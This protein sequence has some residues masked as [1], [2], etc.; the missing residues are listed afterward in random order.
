MALHDGFM[1]FKCYLYGPILFDVFTD[2]HSLL[3]IFR[4]KTPAAT[5]RIFRL[6]SKVN[7]FNFDLH[8][9]KGTHNEMADM[10]SRMSH[11]T[12]TEQIR[13]LDDT[14]CNM[15][16]ESTTVRKSRR[17]QGLEPE[18]APTSQII[19]RKRRAKSTQAD[20]SSVQPVTINLKKIT[21]HQF[22]RTPL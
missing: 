6:M 22:L 2:H 9:V 16:N 5:R 14:M 7:E 8:Y 13:N 18:V 21:H 19:R 4:G 1:A 17:L 15:T 20:H 12:D 10:L 3:G 11:V